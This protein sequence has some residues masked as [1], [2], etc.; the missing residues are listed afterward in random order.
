[1][2]GE[3]K[4]SNNPAIATPEEMAQFNAMTEAMHAMAMRDPVARAA[5]HEA[6]LASPLDDRIPPL[7]TE[8]ARAGRFARLLAT[9]QV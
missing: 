8:F 1:M 4:E 2:R 6:G 7:H 9:V 3:E 5:L